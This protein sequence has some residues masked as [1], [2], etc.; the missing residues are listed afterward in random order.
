MIQR[1]VSWIKRHPIWSALIGLLLLVIL[2][3]VLKPKPP[4]FDYITHVVDRGTVVRQVSASGKIRA[5]NTIK[6]GAEVSGQ[7]MAVL[8]DYNSEVRKGQLLAEIDPTRLRARLQQAQAQ[9][10]LARANE[11]AALAAIARASA[12]ADLQGR[13]YAR[14]K[15]LAQD[16]FVSKSA[17]DVVSTQASVARST[18]K[19]A[20]AQL[21]TARAQIAQAQ[22]EL[23]SASLDLRRTTIMSPI[24]GVVINKLVEPGNTV[25]AS[26]QTPNLFE[27]AADITRMQVE[28]SVDEADIGQIQVGQKVSFTVDSYAEDAFKGLVKQI[29]KAATEN[30][31]VVSY[32]VILEVDNVSGKLLPGMTA[33]VDII[34]GEKADVLRVPTA[35]LRFRPRKSA[36]A[37]LAERAQKDKATPPTL[38]LPLK[39]ELPQLYQPTDDLNKPEAIDVSLGIEGEDFTEIT[40]GRLKSGDK[41]ILRSRSLIK[42]ADESGD[43]SE[44]E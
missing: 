7:I 3:N 10:Q 18:I 37:L 22:A 38:E 39:K 25:V 29:R 41:I 20:Q 27:I 17:L 23:D 19:S 15:Q 4:T 31:N 1:I 11:Q 12:D 43:E 28:A 9:V 33:N 36:E 13:E 2:Y 14:R 6:V 26:F 44:S 30:Q 40:G 5:L 16:G 42:K 35:A 24:D 32:L 8:V 34:T 21:A